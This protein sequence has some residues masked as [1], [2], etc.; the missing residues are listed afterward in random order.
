MVIGIIADPFGLILPEDQNPHSS[1]HIKMKRRYPAERSRLQY[2][3]SSREFGFDDFRPGFLIF[4]LF[5]CIFVSA[6][7]IYADSSTPAKDQPQDE[8]TFGGQ[9]L[10]GRILRLHPTGIEF[11]PIHAKG[12]LTIQYEKIEKIVTQNLFIIFLG[13]VG[14]RWIGTHRATLIFA[15]IRQRASVIVFSKRNKISSS[16]RSW[17]VIFMKILTA[18]VPTVISAGI[19]EQAADT[20]STTAFI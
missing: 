13:G 8:V 16:S 19:S 14:L 5:M 7:Q 9:T 18:S 17:L 15:C 6:A 12:M 2:Q 4:W 20:I 1:S 10:R 3:P 11:E